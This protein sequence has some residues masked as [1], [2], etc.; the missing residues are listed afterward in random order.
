MVL[1]R[2]TY[3]ARTH[4]SIVSFAVISALS[5]A[6]R[7]DST[8]MFEKGKCFAY[9]YHLDKSLSG[10]YYAHISSLISF[11]RCDIDSS[12]IR[13]TSR[14]YLLTVMQQNSTRFFNAGL[15]SDLHF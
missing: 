8:R 13:D 7:E 14:K 2:T 15:D 10:R 6:A 12:K 9:S 11:A 4:I 1:T 3:L 5:L